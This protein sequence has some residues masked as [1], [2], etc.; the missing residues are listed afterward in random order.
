MNRQ[1]VKSEGKKWVDKGIIEKDQLE[2]I[3]KLYPNQNQKPVLLTLAAIFIGL[4][5]LS[6]IASNWGAIPHVA[7]MVIIILAMLGFYLAGD[8]VYRK[9]SE[10]V[11]VSLLI[12]A[13]LIFGSGIFLTGQMYNYTSFSAFPFFIWAL[14]ALLVFALFEE[15]TL[16]IL[17]IIITTVGQ[18]YSVGNFS[19]YHLLLGLLFLFGFGH[20]VY[21]RADWLYG[22]LFAL[23]YMLQAIILSLVEHESFQWLI[24]YLLVL[25]VTGHVVTKPGIRIPFTKLS[26]AGMFILAIWQVFMLEV[27]YFKEAIN[28]EIS[29]IVIWAV[30]MAAAVYLL[31]RSDNLILILN[32]VLFFPFF[33][34][35]AGS[36][37]VLMLLFIYSLGWLLRGY[38]TEEANMVTKGTVAFVI[39][40][41]VAYIQLAWDFMDKSL[42][43][44]IG[45][46]LL[47]LLSY[48]LER[49][50]RNLSKRGQEI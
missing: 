47:F 4:G 6:F 44:F 25:Y 39:S 11:G 29:F 46:I 26:V 50:R 1:Q 36:M 27:D 7:R 41:I 48:F 5:F 9:R 3:L 22:T 30:L 10:A 28:G 18:V 19:E 20:F 35:E 14:S 24:L 17:A 43:F 13:V 21:Q 16:F 23:S 12:I 31:W 8:H 37:L 15:R 45:G 32:L 33:F 42:F 40:T 38:Q 49:K 34:L 2:E